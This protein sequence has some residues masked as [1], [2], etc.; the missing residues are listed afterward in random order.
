MS[1]IGGLLVRLFGDLHMVNQSSLPKPSFI[2]L[3]TPETAG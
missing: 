3:S 1:G 2:T